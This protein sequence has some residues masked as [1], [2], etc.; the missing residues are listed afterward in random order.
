MPVQTRPARTRPVKRKNGRA[1]P[2]ILPREPLTRKAFQ[3]ISEYAGIRASKNGLHIHHFMVEWVLEAERMR[4][5]DLYAWL[6][7]RGY[8]W[9]PRLGFW[10]AEEV[11]Q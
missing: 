5:A 3:A 7:A 6:E 1:V 9:Q 8:K 2:P 4:R 11:K 10:K